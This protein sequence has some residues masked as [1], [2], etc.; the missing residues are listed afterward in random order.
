MRP[1][2]HTGLAVPLFSG[3]SRTTAWPHCSAPALEPWTTYGPWPEVSRY[4]W[5]TRANAAACR[6]ARLAEDA[7]AGRSSY[8]SLGSLGIQGGGS[9]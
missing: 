6:G 2:A 1:V 8:S 7:D 3:S 5:I 4:R 9:L